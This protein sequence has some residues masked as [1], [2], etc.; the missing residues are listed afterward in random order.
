MRL[1]LSPATMAMMIV[2]AGALPALAQGTLDRSKAPTVGL[3][4]KV[5]LPPIV[6]RQ[7][8]NG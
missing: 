8:P 2:A 6:T 3:P 1:K 7:L 4:P 5:T